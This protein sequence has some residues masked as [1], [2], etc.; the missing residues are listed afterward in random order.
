MAQLVLGSSRAKGR[1]RAG[2]DRRLVDVD[3][4]HELS[5]VAANQ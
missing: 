1:G 5:S 3:N 2:F 4:E